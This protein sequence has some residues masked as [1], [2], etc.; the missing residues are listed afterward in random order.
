VTLVEKLKP[1]RNA[2][3]NPIFQVMFAVIKAA[4]QSNAF[5]SLHVTPYVVASGNSPL[6]LTMNLIECAGDQWL[7]QVEYNSNLF[8]DELMARLLGDYVSSLQVILSQ[9]DVRLSDLDGY[10]DTK[11][12]LRH[13]I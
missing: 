2:S 8:D 4:V 11:E 3:Y 10:H 9:P 7:V 13:V 6:D 12:A 5:A 1:V